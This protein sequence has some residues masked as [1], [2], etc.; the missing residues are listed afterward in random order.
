MHYIPQ[1][2]NDRKSE[3]IIWDKNHAVDVTRASLPCNEVKDFFVRLKNQFADHHLFDEKSLQTLQW[4]WSSRQYLEEGFQKPYAWDLDMIIQLPVSQ[5]LLGSYIDDHLKLTLDDL[6]IK[7]QQSFWNISLF[8][9]VVQEISDEQLYVQVDIMLAPWDDTVFTFM[10]DVRYFSGE[11]YALI[12]WKYYL[13]WVHSALLL[14][15]MLKTKWYLMNNL[16]IYREK[17]NSWDESIKNAVT[18]LLATKNSEIKKKTK[19][20]KI[21]NEVVSDW[22]Q[23]GFPLSDAWVTHETKQ[24]ILPEQQKL[25]EEIENCLIKRIY[26]ED[27]SS[28]LSES[29]AWEWVRSFEEWLTALNMKYHHGF[30][31]QD[32]IQS[33]FI[34]YA[35]RLIEK[36]KWTLWFPALQKKISTVFPFIDF[37]EVENLLIKKQEKQKTVL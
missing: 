4:I 3:A 2:P 9:P 15:N 8:I 31:T 16:G 36:N 35:D 5:E 23:N 10:K 12:D 29:F 13:K 20:L 18:E 11:P 28:F 17:Y 34:D 32:E 22:L 21:H 19:K 1:H 6:W 24:N 27:F 25:Y 30:F 14:E 37:S 26:E 33:L 7:Y